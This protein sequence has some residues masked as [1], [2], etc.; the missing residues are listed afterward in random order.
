[1]E[2]MTDATRYRAPILHS[3]L[4]SHQRHPA[5]AEIYAYCKAFCDDVL[6]PIG[7]TK[8]DTVRGTYPDTGAAYCSAIYPLGQ[9]ELVK[10]MAC[11]YSLWAFIDD[12]V[13]AS[14][15]VD[16]IDEML[17]AFIAAIHQQQVDDPEFRLVAAFLGRRLASRRTPAVHVRPATIR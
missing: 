2:S 12:L 3:R 15:D 6:H 7:R 1:M 11:F 4:T 14:T 17:C 5:H 9:T 8:Y 10:Q 16:H 13:D